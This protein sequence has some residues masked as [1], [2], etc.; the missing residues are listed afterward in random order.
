MGRGTPRL[1][2]QGKQDGSGRQSPGQLAR[3]RRRHQGYVWLLLSL[4][5]LVML[6]PL[7]LHFPLINPAG[8][9]WL[10]LG[11]MLNLTRHSDLRFRRV[12]YS[13]GILAVLNEI[14]WVV[15]V[16]INPALGRHLS[17]PHLLIW[18]L[19]IG[20]FLLRQMRGLIREP[21]VTLEV[22]MGAAAGYLLIGYLGG[23][24]LH[25]VQLWEPNAFDPKL[26]PA[27]INPALDLI[28]TAPAM[29]LASF[30]CLTAVA[31]PVSGKDQLLSLTSS[32]LIALMG[33]LYLAVM[34]GL[35]LGRFHRRY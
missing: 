12:F 25:T 35:I 22:V 31:L 14:A 34:I 4:W 9:V 33:Q 30:S 29:V 20:V 1:A 26:F 17:I 32:L 21:Y 18:V 5:L 3:I 6:Q 2:D 13:L 16:V 8:A 27:G 28:H 23:F 7:A 11:M 24:I 15:I 19:F 10:S